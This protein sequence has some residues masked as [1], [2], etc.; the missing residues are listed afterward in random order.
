MQLTEKHEIFLNFLPAN[1][2]KT[3]EAKKKRYKTYTAP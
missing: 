1:V 3:Q 2:K